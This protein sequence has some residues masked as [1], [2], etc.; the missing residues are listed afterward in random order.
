[1]VETGGLENRFALTGNGGSNPSPSATH[2]LQSACTLT[3]LLK[4]A[5]LAA[6]LA[7]LDSFCVLETART[8]LS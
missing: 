8:G 5:E 4:N 2:S 6:Y 1:V 3:I 7:T